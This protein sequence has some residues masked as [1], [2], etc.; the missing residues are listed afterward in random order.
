MRRMGTQLH[1]AAVQ[2]GLPR[3]RVTMQRMGTRDKT[4]EDEKTRSKKNSEL[5]FINN[6]KNLHQ[7]A[8][9]LKD[10]ATGNHQHG[11]T[12]LVL[13]VSFTK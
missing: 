12:E 4:L 3:Q 8:P 5:K 13:I 10:Y 2:T 7:L 6:S 11:D 1:C 9:T